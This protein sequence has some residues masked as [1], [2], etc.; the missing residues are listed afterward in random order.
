MRHDA[1]DALFG[2]DI[3]VYG[4]GAVSKALLPR[5]YAM[6]D[7]FHLHG[8][9]V[10]HIEQENQYQDTGLQIRNIHYWAKECP[11][12]TIL[13]ATSDTYHK[14]IT[15]ICKHEGFKDIIPVTFSLRDAITYT[16]FK[17][18]LAKKRVNLDGDYI[19]LGNAKFINPLTTN[20]YQNLNVFSQLGDIVFPHLF[21]DWN[22][23]S[24][25]PY[26]PDG[27][28]ELS[29]GCTVLDCGA[30]MGTFSAYAASKGCKCYAFEPTPEL[31]PVLHKY[32][33]IY[34]GIIP[35]EAAVSNQKGTAMFHL[36]TYS[37]AA[38]SLLDRVHSTKS[39]MVPTIT[40]DEFVKYNQIEKVD[41]IKADIEG[42]ERLMLEGAQETLLKHAPKLS[43]CTYHFPDD[44]KVL[45]EL[46]LDANPKYTVQYHWE[47]LYAY[48]S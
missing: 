23:L 41:F 5:L 45:T 4:M 9:A 16:F 44:K 33:E 17:D 6:Q 34:P 1:L 31:Q 13:I 26:D 19:E 29:E 24:E 2:K 39:I 15:E 32:T 25:G 37:Y 11:N 8:I 27:I 35:V 12:A 7:I 42:A 14:E 22:L 40:I 10:T 20:L 21:S 3:L 18:Y 28:L 46:I 38:N 47:K 48:V 43:L 30:N 36:S